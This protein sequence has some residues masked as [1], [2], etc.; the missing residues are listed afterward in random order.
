MKKNP[1]KV[2]EKKESVIKYC[3]YCGGTNVHIDAGMY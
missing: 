1:E 2:P 3:A